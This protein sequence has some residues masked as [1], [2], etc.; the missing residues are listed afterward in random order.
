M[1]QIGK[2]LKHLQ[3]A[4]LVK[5]ELESEKAEQLLPTLIQDTSLSILHQNC[6][7]FNAHFDQFITFV[8]SLE[9]SFSVYAISELWCNKVEDFSHYDKRATHSNLSHGKEKQEEE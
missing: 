1:S 6:Q 2:H 5:Y 4:D 9:A 7:S 3:H 8:T